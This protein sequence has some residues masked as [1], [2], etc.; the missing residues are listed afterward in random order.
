[1]RRHL[2]MLLLLLVLVL[3][4]FCD[5]GDVPSSNATLAFSAYKNPPLPDLSY[6]ITISNYSNSN[7]LGTTNEYKINNYNSTVSNALIVKINTNLS[8]NI[9]VDIWFYPFVN[10]YDSYDIYPV[11]YTTSAS[12]MSSN[13]VLC[14]Y[15]SINY[16]YSGTWTLSG[17]T[18][19]DS[20]YTIKPLSGSGINGRITSKIV[21]EKEENG[22]WVSV[23]SIPSQNNVICGFTEGEFVENTIIFS[24]KPNVP[25]NQTPEP[26]MKYSAR[27]RLVITEV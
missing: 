13:Q 11:T 24:M 14:E 19:K 27:I 4:V 22:S 15:N 26:N 18:F 12:S 1:M 8:K 3:P 16:R 25:N 10:E 20:T 6:V 7:I 5:E 9:N 2:F 21:C 17:F 23:S